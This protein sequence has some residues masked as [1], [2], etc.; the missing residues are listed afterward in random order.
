MGLKIR[1]SEITSYLDQINSSLNSK[2]EGLNQI[3]QGMQNFISAPE[4]TGDAWSAAKSYA[5]TA[6]I[7]LLRGQVRANDEIMNDNLTFASRIAEKIEN[8]EIDEDAL[9]RI[10]ERLESQ[11]QA[12]FNRN[13]LLENSPSFGTRNTSSSSDIGSINSQIRT[14]RD[15]IQ[16]LY[17]LEGSCGDLYATAD[18]LL[19]NVSQGLSALTSANC[20]NSSTGLYSTTKLKLDWAKTI[21]KDWEIAK[22]KTAIQK[23]VDEFGM[24]PEQAKLIV[25]FES[26][27]KKYAKK[28]GWTTEQANFEFIR[29]MA[30]MQYGRSDTG[31]INTTIWGISADV[32]NEKDLKE[33]L[34][35]MGYSNSQIDT[36]VSEMNELYKSSTLQNDYIHIMGSLAAI[37]N[38]ST[39]SNIY[40]MGTT[41]FDFRSYFK[42]AAT[43]SADIASGGVSKEDVRAD[44]DAIAI[45]DRLAKNPSDNIDQI[46][47][48]Y[49]DDIATGRINRAEEFLKYYGNG[50][51]QVGYN[52]FMED[53]PKMLVN[54]AN[55]LFIFKSNGWNAFKGDFTNTEEAL[56]EFIELFNNELEGTGK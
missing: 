54:P 53:L 25:A 14:L 44:L 15:E 10:I 7:P 48:K 36:L 17:D 47:R 28:M 52:N 22:E 49:Y 27:F 32:L 16:S 50:D 12:I 31:V 55:M 2:N 20:F 23:L 38:D 13:M 34:K 42:E 46:M 18:L 51:V 21:N 30:S 39:L 3:M 33:I 45:A 40:H 8:E 9:N 11:R 43:W 19:E 6:H 1:V 35:N 24:T 29:I 41:G 26:K 5:E 37:M 56:K 4:L